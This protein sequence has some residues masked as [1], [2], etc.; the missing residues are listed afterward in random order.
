[1]SCSAQPHTLLR[2]LG[3]RKKHAAR[4][5]APRFGLGPSL[6]GITKA[7]EAARSAKN[8]WSAAVDVGKAAYAFSMTHTEW[9]NADGE[10]TGAYVPAL[11]PH[12]KGLWRAGQLGAAPAIRWGQLA[13][14]YKH[15]SEAARA[16]ST[17][18]GPRIGLDDILSAADPASAE[19][20]PRNWRIGLDLSSAA[21]AAFGLAPVDEPEYQA[22]QAERA[23]QDES[24]EARAEI[25]RMAAADGR[26]EA[27]GVPWWKKLSGAV[28]ETGERLSYARTVVWNT[29]VAISRIAFPLAL[30]STM[31]FAALFACC[32]MLSSSEGT[33]PSVCAFIRAVT[34]GDGATQLIADV[35]GNGGKAFSAALAKSSFQLKIANTDNL[36]RLVA[37]KMPAWLTDAGNSSFLKGAFMKQLDTLSVPTK[38]STWEQVW[39][40]AFSLDAWAK[41]F[42]SGSAQ[43]SP[44]ALL[45]K[46]SGEVDPQYLQVIQKLYEVQRQGLVGD[47]LDDA[48]G[49]LAEDTDVR[50]YAARVADVGIKGLLQHSEHKA[51]VENMHKFAWQQF[52]PLAVVFGR[53]QGGALRVIGDAMGLND[54]FASKTPQIGA[55]VVALAGLAGFYLGPAATASVLAT[56]A[57]VYAGYDLTGDPTMSVTIAVT[58]LSFCR[59]FVP[60]TASESATLDQYTQLATGLAGAMQ[61]TIHATRAAE[62]E[63]AM[64]KARVV[65]DVV[66][67]VGAAAGTIA[68]IP[69]GPPGMAAGAAAGGGI[70]KAIGA[71]VTTSAAQ[72]AYVPTGAARIVDSMLNFGRPYL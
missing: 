51:F 10:V 52:S 44:Q 68:G 71:G 50:A 23:E 40:S 15:A 31:V 27:D 16:A 6:G 19:K 45:Q 17:E 8:A 9:V 60:T 32:S 66:E 49:K 57:A 37:T 70:G 72:S 36:D 62:R 28:S 18:Q 65:S 48:V 34:G 1:M 4:E 33:A 69:Y 13:W 20:G 42:T 12:V 56:T 58:V 11:T 43:K 38:E 24:R 21:P 3:I 26:T 47:A 22:E 59:S 7:V 61:E 67:G 25:E 30:L 54:D 5:F 63:M 14:C 39:S 53:A 55:A 46:V 64:A 41:Y 2:E 35:S 29:L